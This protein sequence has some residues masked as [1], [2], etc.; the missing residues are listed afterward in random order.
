MMAPILDQV[1]RIIF[2]PNF[3]EIFVEINGYEEHNSGITALH[4][5]D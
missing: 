4:E 1:V 3:G 2:P 5:T